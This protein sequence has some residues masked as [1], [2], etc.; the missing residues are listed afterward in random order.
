MADEWDVTGAVQVAEAYPPRLMRRT[1]AMLA[2][3][4]AAGRLD[5][6]VN[7]GAYFRWR[8]ENDSRMESARKTAGA[9]D[10]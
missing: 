3:E 7:P 1:L 5:D 2:R 9:S 8:I 10:E 6:V 4:R